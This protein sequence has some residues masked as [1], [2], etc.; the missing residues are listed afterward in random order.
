MGFDHGA[1]F[2]QENS[3]VVQRRS[4]QEGVVNRGKLEK[5]GRNRGET[6]GKPMGFTMVLQ[7][8]EWEKAVQVLWKMWES[9]WVIFFGET[10]MEVSIPWKTPT[11]GRFI[12]WKIPPKNE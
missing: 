5:Y 1:D 12:S 11:A 7:K 10:Q 4:K 2:F 8:S 9:N 6:I 3:D